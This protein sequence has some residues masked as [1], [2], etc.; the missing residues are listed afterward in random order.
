MKII[1]EIDSLLLNRKEILVKFE[2]INKPTPKKEEVKKEIASKIKKDE[3]LIEIKSIEGIYG[4]NE[5]LVSAN[6]YS[7]EASKKKIEFINK[8]KKEKTT[9]PEVKKEGAKGEEKKEPAKPVEEKKVEIKEEKPKK[10]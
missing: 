5:S 6:I 7:D 10:E 8:K 3:K 4:S 9:K 1:A 2:H